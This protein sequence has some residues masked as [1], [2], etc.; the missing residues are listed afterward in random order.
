MRYCTAYEQH[1]FT[2]AHPTAERAARELAE[3]ELAEEREVSHDID[4]LRRD[5]EMRVRLLEGRLK[6]LTT[7]YTEQKEYWQQHNKFVVDRVM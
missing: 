4:T 1:G 5:A 2:L 6:S 3:E 7:M